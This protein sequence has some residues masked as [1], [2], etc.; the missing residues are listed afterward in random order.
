MARA[1]SSR[2]AS[3][4]ATQALGLFWLGWPGSGR[5]RRRRGPVPPTADPGALVYLHGGDG[6]GSLARAGSRRRPA[7]RAGGRARPPEALGRASLCRAQRRPR[8][9]RYARRRPR[10]HPRIT[11]L[12]FALHRHTPLRLILS[13]VSMNHQ[14]RGGVARR[15]APARSAHRSRPTRPRLSALAVRLAQRALPPRRRTS[16]PPAGR[17]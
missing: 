3:G 16:S 4:R 6:G 10:T 9:H 13:K 2:G 11:A 7:A 17:C 14:S 8:T 5:P 1:M 12:G 15:A